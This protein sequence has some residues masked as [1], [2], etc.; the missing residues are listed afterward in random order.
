MNLS[1]YLLRCNH[2]DSITTERTSIK[3]H[4]K[5]YME[6]ILKVL[7]SFSKESTIILTLSYQF[8]YDLDAIYKDFLDF[9]P[10][11]IYFLISFFY[12]KKRVF[13]IK[14]GNK[15]S[16]CIIV[17]TIKCSY[18]SWNVLPNC[19]VLMAK[20]NLNFCAMFCPFSNTRNGLTT[21]FPLK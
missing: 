6:V 16:W 21:G 4:V 17:W 2:R 14:Y 7:F 1:W 9:R 20:R 11:N 12:I 5:S 18:L 3:I 10:F 19:A 8:F 13:K 15:T